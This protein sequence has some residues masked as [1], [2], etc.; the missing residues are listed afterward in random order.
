MDV[1][2]KLLKLLA[3][4]QLAVA[5]RQRRS[6]SRRRSPPSRPS[7]PPSQAL[8]RLRRGEIGLAAYLDEKIDQALAPLRELLHESDVGFV[9]SILLEKVEADPILSSIVAR[10]GRLRPERG[11]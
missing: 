4:A 5:A 10:I 3:E 8:R 2:G 6:A 1:L 11:S 9:R 7:R